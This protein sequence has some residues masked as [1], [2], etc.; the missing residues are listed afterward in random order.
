MDTKQMIKLL[1]ADLTR[2]YEAMNFYLQCSFTV[3][4][5]R[6]GYLKGWLR[7]QAEEEL[8]HASAIADKISTLGAVPSAKI[9]EVKGL[10]NPIEILKQ[11]IRYENSVVEN[12]KE[13]V[14]DAD[15]LGDVQLRMMLE[16]QLAES[17]GEAEEL[18]KFL[19]E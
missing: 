5:Y 14:K 9:P 7:K 1:Q 19:E 16:E 6:R 4:G 13:R 17:Q 15:E 8:G 10:R 11:A 12:F 2:E 18:K 3:R